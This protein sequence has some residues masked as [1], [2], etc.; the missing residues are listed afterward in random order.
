MAHDAH[1]LRHLLRR[2]T[3]VLALLVALPLSARAVTV[4]GQPSRAAAL[5]PVVLWAGDNPQDL[6]FLEG[7]RVGIAFLACTLTLMPDKV[8]TQPRLQPM[9][10]PQ[11]ART[12]PVVRIE[13]DPS[14]KTPD[15]SPARRHEIVTR[16]SNMAKLSGTRAVQIDFDAPASARG[17][18]RALL[19]DLRQ[20]LPDSTALSMTAP[21]AWC[22]GEAWIRNLAVDEV[23]P[24]VYGADRDE[25]KRQ[26]GLQKDFSCRSCRGSLGLSTGEPV[27]IT[28]TTK[29]VYL[30]HEGSWT[31]E[32]FEATLARLERGMPRGV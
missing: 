31:K 20:E 15:L 29:R 14:G 3:L 23:V 2:A 10:L 8:A 19:S 11:D 9:T 28:R 4:A 32:A 12:Y 5:P 6:R 25:L 27:W 22:M 26:L 13:L 21:L 7:R 16:L 24:T 1:M 30:H 18:Y 17:F